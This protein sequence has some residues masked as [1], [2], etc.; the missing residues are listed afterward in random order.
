MSWERPERLDRALELLAEAPRVVLGGGTDLYAATARRELA[1]DV[2][3]VTAVAELRGIG[4][5]PQGVRIGA[6]ATWTEVIRA[7]LPPAFHGFAAAAREVGSAQIQNRGTV[8]GNLCNASPAADGVPALLTLGAEVELASVR[9]VRRLALEAFLLGPRRTAL[10]ADEL[11]VAVHAP[12]AGCRGRGG[13]AKLGAR[14]HLV[15]SIG[16][17]A[18]RVEVEGGRV[19][20]AAL[21]MGACGP[22]AVRM[23]EVEAALAGVPVGEVAAAVTEAA[24][25]ARLSPIDDIRAEAGY[26]RRAAAE[27]ARR[28]LAQALTVEEAAA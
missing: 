2:L 5:G 25:A 18:A 24:A 27:L 10:E 21:A 22:V 28:A 1:G 6:A 11:M 9:G 13:F 26:R 7:G 14:R 3:D 16:M 4:A 23:P 12:P 20:R 8:A 15:I 17:C 19:A